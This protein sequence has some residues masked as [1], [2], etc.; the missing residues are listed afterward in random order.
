ML[1]IQ[2]PN[3][4]QDTHSQVTWLAAVSTSRSHP[5]TT[6]APTWATRPC[7]P[8]LSSQ[9]P[10]NITSR[11]QPP[12]LLLRQQELVSTRALLPQIITTTN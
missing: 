2:R 12:P 10:Q 5:W 11:L 6:L 4:A 8:R 7:L 3:P 1:S 9:N